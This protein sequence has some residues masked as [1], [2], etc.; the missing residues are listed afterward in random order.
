ML[1]IQPCTR[2]AGITEAS[3][4]SAFS[5]GFSFFSCIFSFFD[6]AA[7]RGG[8]TAR[9]CC[10]QGRTLT[11]GDTGYTGL[12]GQVSQRHFPFVSDGSNFPR[13][14]LMF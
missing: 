11:R 7:L 9:C 14:H 8:S 5:K 12:R 1:F 10:R 3:S 2:F 6:S 4:H 13:T